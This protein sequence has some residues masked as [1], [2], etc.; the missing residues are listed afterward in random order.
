MKTTHPK[1]PGFFSLSLNIALG[2]VKLVCLDPNSECFE[3][4]P[5]KTL[6][7]ATLTLKL[8]CSREEND[9][10]NWTSLFH[11]ISYALE[12]LF[13]RYLPGV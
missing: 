3:V 9:A 5:L 10:R 7:L 6:I 12:G 11:M 1:R 8:V 4:L 2:E 13:V